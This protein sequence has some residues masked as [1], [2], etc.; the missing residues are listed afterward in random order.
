MWLFSGS[1]VAQEPINFNPMSKQFK[2]AKALVIGVS[3]Y[4]HIKGLNFADRDAIEF[5][6]FLQENDGWGIKEENIQLLTNENAKQGDILMGLQWLLDASV[7]GEDIV[8]YFSGHG[9]VEKV[10]EEKKGFLLAH[11]SPKNNYPIGGTL[12]ISLL[13]SVLVQL[14]KKEVKIW[15]IIDACRSGNLAGGISGKT[16]T[17]EALAKQ[18]NNQVRMLSAQPDQLSYEDSL[19]GG[20]RGVF[21]YYLVKGMSGYANANNDTKVTLNELESYLGNNITYQTNYT[22]QP[23]VE[24]PNK[25][26]L[27]VSLLDTVQMQHYNNDKI[28]GEVSLA[29]ISKAGEYEIAMECQQLAEELTTS[30][31]EGFKP[32]SFHLIVN[33]WNKLTTCTKQDVPLALRYHYMRSLINQINDV[34]NRSLSGEKMGLE[35]DLKYGIQLI[36]KLNEMNVGRP[37]LGKEHF[38]RVNHYLKTILYTSYSEE[39][40]A[41]RKLPYLIEMIHADPEDYSWSDV[42]DFQ[43]ELEDY[44]LEG[45][46]VLATSCDAS[47]K[48]SLLIESEFYDVLNVVNT[49]D[50]YLEG[51]LKVMALVERDTMLIY[52]R[53][54]YNDK[55][56]NHINAWNFDRKHNELLLEK[57]RVDC[58]FEPTSA[59]LY[60]SRSLLYSRIKENDSALIM[61]DKCIELSPKW[62][63]PLYGKGALLR[64]MK[65]NNDAILA[66]EQVFSLESTYQ[67]FEC[68]DCFFMGLVNLYLK[69]K[70][71]DKIEPTIDRW[72]NMRK[73]NKN[74]WDLYFQLLTD[75]S[76]KRSDRKYWLQK[77]EKIEQKTVK[78]QFRYL[79][80]YLYV[81]RKKYSDKEVI[82]FTH[83]FLKELNA[84]DAGVRLFFED[85]TFERSG[86]SKNKIIRDFFQYGR[87]FQ[88]S[89]SMELI[90]HLSAFVEE[91]NYHH[92][93]KQKALNQEYFMLSGILRFKDLESYLDWTNQLVYE[94]RR[95]ADFLN[96]IVDSGPYDDYTMAFQLRKET[97]LQLETKLQ[98]PN[99][100]DEFEALDIQGTIDEIKQEIEEIKL[101]DAGY[102]YALHFGYDPDRFVELYPSLYPK[103]YF[104][105]FLNSIYNDFGFQDEE[106]LTGLC[107]SFSDFETLKKIKELMLEFYYVE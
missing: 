84:G 30:L 88:Y 36:D 83:F 68:V 65:R 107:K 89:N 13:D 46:K 85:S 58:E 61:L 47:G 76:A 6:N 19:W 27:G 34:V 52:T 22:Q 98:N 56:E 93:F 87:S 63:T 23:H 11:D 54:S 1:L 15:V 7:P 103:G 28:E 57:L 40:L 21:S 20:G 29:M 50:F 106:Y 25:F 55:T 97:I 81:H 38:D 24:G 26:S 42:E 66:F 64:A 17:S 95:N 18:W 5:T 70:T 90:E 99:V 41:N 48:C 2:D 67:E 39:Y 45:V 77:M 73:D 78:D 60:Y 86:L 69:E 91:Q 31:T 94:K 43:S 101:T 35:P 74:R 53:P 71:H 14:M 79:Y 9:D 4:Q 10:G 75:P 96:Q 100:L 51:K 33:T 92:L 104:F 12:E 32:S 37:F 16:Q 44:S 8:F 80:S 82:D 105:R 72:L 49:F 3:Q 59:Y 62:L 102:N